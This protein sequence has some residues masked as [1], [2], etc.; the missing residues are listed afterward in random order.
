MTPRPKWF[1]R[2]VTVAIFIFIL[3]CLVAPTIEPVTK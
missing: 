1:D 3:T 2:L